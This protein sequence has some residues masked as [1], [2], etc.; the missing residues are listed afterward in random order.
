[1][2]GKAGISTGVYLV[3]VA[4]NGVMENTTNSILVGDVVEVK[5][6]GL[7]RVTELSK[8]GGVAYLR[9]LSANVSRL[10]PTVVGVKALLRSEQS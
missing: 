1:M 5:G 10:A 8:C 9:Y 2:H 7:A 6:H 4:Y 3:A